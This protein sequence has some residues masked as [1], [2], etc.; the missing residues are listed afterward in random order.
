MK[1]E[2]FQTSGSGA[3][4]FTQEGKKKFITAWQEHKREQIM[5]PYL[6]EKMSWGLVPHVQALLLARTLRGDIEEYPPFL[7][8]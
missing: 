3:V 8:K 1:K 5:H 7:W 2:H 6:Q 4:E